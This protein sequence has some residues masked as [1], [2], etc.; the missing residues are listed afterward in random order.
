[1]LHSHE[2]AA[3]EIEA[4]VM[5]PVPGGRLIEENAGNGHGA[6]LPE[7]GVPC[8]YGGEKNTCD[9]VAQQHFQMIL[10]KRAAVVGTAYDGRIAS[11]Y[12]VPLHIRGQLGIERVGDGGHDD[13]DHPVHPALEHLAEDVGPVVKFFHYFS[14]S[15]PEFRAY[16][17]VRVTENPGHGRCGGFRLSGDIKNGRPFLSGDHIRKVP[18]A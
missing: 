18:P 16:G 12:A 11:L 10:L 6:E 5:P 15:T 7:E 1:M 17:V 14:D 4:Y 2:S 8:V 9:L 13:A 3:L